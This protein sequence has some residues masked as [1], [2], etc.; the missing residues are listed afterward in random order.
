MIR[1]RSGDLQ[2]AI[3]RQPTTV[4]VGLP[5]VGVSTGKGICYERMG[6]TE[7]LR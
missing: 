2:V 5:S 4:L 7:I 3:V 6:F 1:A